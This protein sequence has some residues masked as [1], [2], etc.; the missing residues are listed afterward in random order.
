MS[1]QTGLFLK[2][3]AGCQ[4]RPDLRDLIHVQAG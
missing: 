2:A 1:L 4:N 3:F